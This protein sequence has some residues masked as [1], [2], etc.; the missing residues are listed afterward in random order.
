MIQNV[1]SMGLLFPY[2][3]PQFYEK[4]IFDG[5]GNKQDYIFQVSLEEKFLPH[6]NM[7]WFLK[8]Y[9]TWNFLKSKVYKTSDVRKRFFRKKETI[10]LQ[11]TLWG[12]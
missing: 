11:L 3:A 9:V 2:N 7:G 1:T 8:N 5:V 6:K 10:Q 12:T 4:L